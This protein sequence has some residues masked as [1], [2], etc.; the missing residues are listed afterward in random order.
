[1]DQARISYSI[2][3]KFFDPDAPSRDRIASKMP[4]AEQTLGALAH[5]IP[6]DSGL[7]LHRTPTGCKEFTMVVQQGKQSNQ[8]RTLE[9]L[10]LESKVSV[11]E[12]ARL[13]EDE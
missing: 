2:A 3:S 6:S 5:S 4:P 9:V 1:M 10:A 7:L 11:D 12:V 8:K 13:Y